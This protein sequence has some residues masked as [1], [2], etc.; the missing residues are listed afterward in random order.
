MNEYNK[1]HTPMLTGALL[2]LCG[3][4][5]GLP[6]AAA[7]Y[8]HQVNA[9]PHGTV[10]IVGVSGQIQVSAWD[11]AEVR[12]EGRLDSG[13][14]RVDVSSETGRTVVKVVLPGSLSFG[15]GSAELRVS[16][17]R[18]S[19]LDV[20][21]ISAG[22]TGVQGDQHLRSVSGSINTEFAGQEAEL[23]TVSGDLF[24][25]GNG[26]PARLRANTI[27]GD[28]RLENAGG[29]VEAGTVSGSLNAH[30][31][32]AVTVRVR[33]TSGTI[34]LEGLLYSGARLEAQTLSGELH[35]RAGGGGGYQ[36]EA[37][38]FSGHIANCFNVLPERTSQYGPGERLHGTF[39][40]GS[41]QV[42]LKT[43][44]GGITLCDH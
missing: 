11:R 27:S 22:V 34:N 2:G 8:E 38:T 23:K 25:R 19:T 28:L 10:E 14:E 15:S 18:G 3:V 7:D 24:V 21:S 16:V 37:S 5:G 12:V 40:P 1:M 26:K 43:L 20:S 13:V 31:D 39:G 33:T 36:Y 32:P 29:D 17:P 6:A 4:L 44:S 41:G 30:V 42:T 9:D 35:V